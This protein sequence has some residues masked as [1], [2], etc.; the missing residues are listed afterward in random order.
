MMKILF[1]FFAVFGAQLCLAE[2]SDLQF[3]QPSTSNSFLT[4]KLEKTFMPGEGPSW[5]QLAQSRIQS[6]AKAKARCT[7]GIDSNFGNFKEH[8]DVPVSMIPFKRH[9]Y[10]INASGMRKVEIVKW[11]GTIR[12]DGVCMPNAKADSFNTKVWGEALIKSDF[13]Q[14][15]A[16]L[17]L[18]SKSSL[19]FTSRI[20]KPD[21]LKIENSKIAI[22]ATPGLQ[23]NF[24]LVA[25]VEPNSGP[26][27]S[28]TQI[29]L[30]SVKQSFLFA[31]WKTNTN[32]NN[33]CQDMV[34]LF[35]LATEIKPVIIKRYNCD[36]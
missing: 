28:L 2:T 15:E 27:N 26:L 34:A 19:V 13:P 22:N 10:L 21:E 6:F 16:S 36:V 24:T 32:I 8:F 33:I 30:S 12:Y 17:I 31:R 9:L 3:V 11:R 25:P 20:R 23:G 14:A 29:D 7:G 35:E 4:V 1:G 5:E 18:V